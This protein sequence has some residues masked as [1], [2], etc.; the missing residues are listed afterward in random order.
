MCRTNPG[1]IQLLKMVDRFGDPLLACSHEVHTSGKQANRLVGRQLAN[2]LNRIDHAGMRAAEKDRRSFSSLNVNSLII[3]DGVG[4]L[5]LTVDKERST[6]VFVIGD[7][8]NLPSGVDAVGDSC[9]VFR[10][11]KLPQLGTQISA[12]VQLGADILC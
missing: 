2:V 10:T 7:S 5:T 4:M 9:G 6:S 11:H 12:V 3:K 8:G 1:D